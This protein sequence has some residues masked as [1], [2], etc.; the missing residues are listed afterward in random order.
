MENKFSHNCY[1]IISKIGVGGA[2]YSESDSFRSRGRTKSAL[3]KDVNH[4]ENCI[5]IVGLHS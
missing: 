5:F 3:V 2:S 4:P 1:E